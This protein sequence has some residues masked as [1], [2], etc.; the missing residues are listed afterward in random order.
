MFTYPIPSENV[1]PCLDN[2]PLFPGRDTKAM[3]AANQRFVPHVFADRCEDGLRG[4]RA[5][6]FREIEFESQARAKPSLPIKGYADRDIKAMTALVGG[7]E[8]STAEYLRRLAADGFIYQHKRPSGAWIIV[9]RDHAGCQ[10]LKDIMR[11]DEAKAK[12]EDAARAARKSRLAETTARNAARRAEAGALRAAAKVR[13]AASFSFADAPNFSCVK[14][15]KY[16]RDAQLSLGFTPIAVGAKPTF[17]GAIVSKTG[18]LL[19]FPL[20]LQLN[21]SS[22]C[23]ITFT[24]CVYSGYPAEDDDDMEASLFVQDPESEPPVNVKDEEPDE[25]GDDP[26]A[27]DADPWPPAVPEA[28]GAPS[29]PQPPAAP[30]PPA[31]ASAPPPCPAQAHA[32]PAY[33]AVVRSFIEEFCDEKCRPDAVRKAL[34]KALEG[35]SPATA[36]RLCVESLEVVNDKIA[37]G[38]DIDQKWF[39]LFSTIKN[40]AAAVRKAHAEAPRVY[41]APPPP[42]PALSKTDRNKVNEA[43]AAMDEK[44]REE[45]VKATKALLLTSQREGKWVKQY[46][47]NLQAERMGFSSDTGWKAT[48]AQRQAENL[49]PVP[50]PAPSRS[51]PSPPAPPPAPSRPARSGRPAWV[52]E[53]GGDDAYDTLSVSDKAG[54]LSRGEAALTAAGFGG[55]TARA[56]EVQAKSLYR[57]RQT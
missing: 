29:A 17:L 53:A 57:Q 6:I 23:S 47:K 46:A 55:V 26:F 51:A 36:T 27:D 31:P 18:V 19:L 49:V 34:A 2:F 5:A 44:E 24:P 35:A 38:K 15:Q 33:E 30:A 28:P 12:A 20:N 8:S 48:D 52:V 32:D 13:S 42:E 14:A 1:K 54:W 10:R 39:Y 50:G 7:E 40:A 9:I 3:K 21:L 22:S 45:L 43:M 41:F 16:L 37:Q 56:I 11:Q 25:L 4:V